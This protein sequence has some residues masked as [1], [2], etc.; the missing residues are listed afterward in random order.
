MSLALGVPVRISELKSRGGPREPDYDE[1]K[2][3][4]KDVAAYGDVLLFGGDGA[5]GLMTDLIRGLAV[6]AFVPGG[7]KICE[8]HFDASAEIL[9][10]RTD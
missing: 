9:L 3:I 4:A 8:L 2:S 5:A 6:M 10:Q 1:L 7:I